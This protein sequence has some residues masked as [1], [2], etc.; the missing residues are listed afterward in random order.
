MG[1]YSSHGLEK[2][3]NHGLGLPVSKVQH[4]APRKPS[5][6]SLVVVAKDKEKSKK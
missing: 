1:D 4:P 3:G 5:E 6:P 2:H